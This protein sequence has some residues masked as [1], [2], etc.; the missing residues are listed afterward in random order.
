MKPDLTFDE[1]TSTLNLKNDIRNDSKIEQNVAPKSTGDYS[2]EGDIWL[3]AGRIVHDWESAHRTHLRGKIKDIALYASFIQLTRKR[4]FT[5]QDL[6]K[7]Y[8]YGSDYARRKIYLLQKELGLLV[9][10]KGRRSGRF[11][12]Y[13]IS[14][15]LDKFKDK[16]GLSPNT[17]AHLSLK[18]G[19]EQE[20]CQ[21]MQTST[22]I[23]HLVAILNRKEFT[24][25]KLHLYTKLPPDLYAGI[26]WI[27]PSTRNKAK[28]KE[29]PLEF[30]RSVGFEI[31]P[32]GTTGIQMISTANPYELHTPS[33]IIDFT[34]SLGEA[35]SILKTECKDLHRIPPVTS[36]S[37]KMFDKDKTV[38]VSEI[39][40]DIPSVMKWWSAEGIRV[41][42]LGYA[43]QI[44]GK[45]MPETGPTFR[46]EVQSTVEDKE[47]D[48][49]EAILEAT[50]PEVKINTAL[51]L[52]NRRVE[53]LED[54]NNNS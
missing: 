6:Q 42:H 10:L 53:R 47:K 44:Y 31:F 26:D 25:H 1:S 49:S 38:S 43:F 29:F 22:F 50:F 34:S 32:N 7:R 15:E 37:L 21:P 52:L 28:V 4:G 48:L 46:L 40:K 35:R 54:N 2:Y 27:V 45:V 39:E 51:E 14:T 18:Q 17:R 16:A 3:E 36:W 12:Q 19:E 9:P 33:G 5:R 8:N 11:Q 41:E 23:Q 13:C 20:E 24:F 30:R